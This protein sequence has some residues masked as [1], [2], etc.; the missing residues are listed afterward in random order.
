MIVVGTMLTV[1]DNSG[2]WRVRCIK[3]LRKFRYMF[4]RPGSVLV[5]TVR[6]LRKAATKRR[7]SKTGSLYFGV[8]TCTKKEVA[9]RVGGCVIQ[10]F[11][12]SVV[13]VNE[14][15]V[16]IARRV[17]GPVFFEI[18]LVG[19]LRIGLLARGLI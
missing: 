16:P 5:V 18:R 2:A 15:F 3:I 12:N 1:G 17:L 6:R 8:L 10:F 4:G 14:E 7:V 9:R 13:L 11:T 19:R